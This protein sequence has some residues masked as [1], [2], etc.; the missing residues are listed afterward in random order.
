MPDCRIVAGKIKNIECW[1][2]IL[3]L[4]KFLLLNVRSEKPLVENKFTIKSQI[5]THILYTN[6]T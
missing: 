3:N 4:L 6:P 2:F 5:I 1:L